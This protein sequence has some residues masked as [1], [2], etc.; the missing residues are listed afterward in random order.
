MLNTI[1]VFLLYFS[2]STKEHLKLQNRQRTNYYFRTS[3]FSTISVT[4]STYL[5]LPDILDHRLQ[6]YQLQYD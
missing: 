2:S 1:A 6:I 4:V 3:K 5:I